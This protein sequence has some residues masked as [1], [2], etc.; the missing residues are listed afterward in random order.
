MPSSSLFPQPSPGGGSSAALG[1]V[2]TAG[3][4]VAVNTASQQHQHMN[5]ASS[6]LSLNSLEMELNAGINGN[7]TAAASNTNGCLLDDLQNGSNGSR[8]TQLALELAM[9]QQTG[10]QFDSPNSSNG[11][12]PGL[13]ATASLGA[14]GV[15][16][17]TAGSMAAMLNPDNPLL[18]PFGGNG[19]SVSAMGGVGGSLEDLKT[20]RSQNMTECVPVPTSEHVAEIVGRQG[21]RER[22][23]EHLFGIHCY[24][25]SSIDVLLPFPFYLVPSIH[26]PPHTRLFL[27][28]HHP[29]PP[30]L[31]I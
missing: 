28:T 13:T 25:F 26:P 3:G 14:G 23:N 15:H 20:R 22:K 19:V 8:M 6:S 1:G 17:G 30:F 11:T 4:V 21:R 2:A 18:H 31:S 5:A 27:S 7:R 9:L 24:Y 29:F 10:A 16:G 12:H